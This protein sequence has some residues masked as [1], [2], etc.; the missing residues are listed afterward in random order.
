MKKIT[1]L[2]MSVAAVLIAAVPA[3][4]QQQCRFEGDSCRYRFCDCGVRR[5]TRPVTYWRGS[6]R[7]RGS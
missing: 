2:L 1:L 5:R 4:A 3:L 6:L 7:G